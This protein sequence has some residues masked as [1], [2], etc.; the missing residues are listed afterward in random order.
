MACIGTELTVAFASLGLVL[1]LSRLSFLLSFYYAHFLHRQSCTEVMTGLPP[2]P[3][4]PGSYQYQ[5]PEVFST[6][7]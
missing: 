7:P 4:E 6:S 5:H 3:N 2:R 1:S